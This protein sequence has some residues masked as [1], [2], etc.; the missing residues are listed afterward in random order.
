MTA[1]EPIRLV[2]V[3]GG[4]ASGKSLVSRWFERQGWTLVDADRVAHG[5]YAPGTI[6][7]ASIAE[8]FGPSVRGPDGAI[9]RKAL[10]A[11]VF[12]DPVALARL[13]ALVHPAARQE[14]S[15]IVD[16]AEVAGDRLA[17]EMA[18]LSRWPAMARRFDAVVGVSAPARLRRD[19]LM[20]RN[21]LSRDE[22][23]SRL[24]R[25]E[26]EEVLLGCA[27]WTVVNDGTVEELERRL[28]EKFR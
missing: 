3:T 25:Q 15:A 4:I 12:A 9:D 24:A 28:A 19:R 21:G 6:L 13:D 16:R 23:E 20:E 26:A 5:L 8:A 1:L 14:L 22:A 11:L 18:L 7:N 2:A 10:G 27:T 17:L